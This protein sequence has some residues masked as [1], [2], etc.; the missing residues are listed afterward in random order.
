MLESYKEE[1]PAFVSET[2]DK[3]LT[4]FEEIKKEIKK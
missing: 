3:L 4:Y 2:K 1:I